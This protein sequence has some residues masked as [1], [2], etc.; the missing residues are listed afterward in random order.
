MQ[1]PMASGLVLSPQAWSDETSD[2]FPAW[3]ML[4]L[5]PSGSAQALVAPVEF[6]IWCPRQVVVFELGQWLGVPG[7]LVRRERQP[8]PLLCS[9]K[10]IQVKHSHVS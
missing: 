10:L 1:Q 3:L 9:P 4:P 7:L 5:T 2:A 8:L 6:Q